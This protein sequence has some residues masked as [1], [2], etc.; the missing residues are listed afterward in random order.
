MAQN[1]FTLI[2]QKGKNKLALAA[3]GGDP[4]NIR[5]MAIGDGGGAEVNPSATA[6]AL[7]REVWRTQVES[8]VVDETNLSAVI[9][10]AV[11]PTMV[12]GWWIREIGIFDVASDMIAVVKPAAEYKPIASEGQ[13]EDILYEFQLIVGEDAKVTMM[14][15][16][17]LTWATRDYV[18]TRRMPIG[19][20]TAVPWL[21][22]ISMTIQAPPPLAK[23]GDIYLIPATPKGDWA[24][25]AGKLAEWTGSAWLYITPPDGHGIGLPDGTVYTRV[26]E[27]YVEFLASR[28]YVDG[29]K[30]PLAQINR[31]PWI[32][33]ISNTLSAPP[34]KPAQGDTYIVA[35]N[36]SGAWTSKVGQIAEWTGSDWQVTQPANGHGVS[37][38]DGRVLISLEGGWREKIAEDVRSGKWNYALAGGTANALT[39]TLNPA[40]AEDYYPGLTVNLYI[41]KAS[42]DAVTFDAGKGVKPL[43]QPGGAALQIGAL[44]P[45]YIATARYTDIGGG[46]WEIMS[47]LASSPLNVRAL[48]FTIPGTYR[49]AVPDGV[50]GVYAYVWAGGGGGGGSAN[51]S[52]IAAGEGGGGGG[53]SEGWFAVTPGQTIIIVVGGG[54]PAG[55]ARGAAGDGQSSSFGTFCSATGGAGGRYADLSTT[56]A[57]V[58]GL[59][60]G[61]FINLQGGYGWVISPNGTNAA[62]GGS[63]GGSP[64]GGQTGCNSPYGGAS[65][66]A[67]GGGGGGSGGPGN[68]PGT[69]GAPG[70]VIVQW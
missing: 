15:D 67:P 66:L 26:K 51:A 31:L 16:P 64:N 69:A 28:S 20:L 62:L 34:A 11:I 65:A 12:G 21:P 35:S 5:F 59:G 24:G 55:P 40:L 14:V 22:V 27:T 13:L 39:A 10:R 45:G 30:V 52:V 60:V 50:Y 1:Y 9:I 8:V 3:A 37:L 25:K 68:I 33:V 61:G 36:A 6:N 63:G 42:T 29:R 18:N 47:P 53:Y 4:I 7:V 2:T 32:P 54:G 41:T 44:T 46:R 17:S 58:G 70:R 56:F 19:Q 48:V 49:W 38:P 57:R 43:T 23:I